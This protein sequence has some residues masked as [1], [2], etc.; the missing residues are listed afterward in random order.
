MESYFLTTGKTN[1]TGV[2]VFTLPKF[3]GK[4]YEVS[5]FN[6]ANIKYNFKG[7]YTPHQTTTDSFFSHCFSMMC[8]WQHEVECLWLDG[9]LVA[10][11]LKIGGETK[12]TG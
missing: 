4:A 11:N 2:Q 10:K 9:D 12:S 6:L 8:A 5:L 1:G 3:T 7:L